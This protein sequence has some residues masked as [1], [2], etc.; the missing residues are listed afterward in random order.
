MREN[1]NK[2]IEHL[3]NTTYSFGEHYQAENDYDLVLR[4]LRNIDKTDDEICKILADYGCPPAPD[5]RCNSILG[6]PVTCA[7]CWKAFLSADWEGNNV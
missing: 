2:L 5:A 3:K 1:L 6:L 7:Q 4:I